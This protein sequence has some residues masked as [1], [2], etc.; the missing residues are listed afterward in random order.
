MKFL[1]YDQLAEHDVPFTPKHIRDLIARGKFPKPVT[2]GPGK[3]RFIASE[4]EAWKQARIAERDI[5][6]SST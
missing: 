4:I 1:T 6:A 5:V 2:F 3:K